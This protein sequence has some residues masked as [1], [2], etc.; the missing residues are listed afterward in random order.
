MTVVVG[1]STQWISRHAHTEQAPSPTQAASHNLRTSSQLLSPFVAST[2]AKRN[3]SS[4]D[5]DVE[6]GA[7]LMTQRRLSP[8]AKPYIAWLPAISSMTK[9]KRT[10]SRHNPNTVGVVPTICSRS[11][12]TIANNSNDSNGN[13][14]KQRTVVL[15][16]YVQTLRTITI[17]I[18]NGTLS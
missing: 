18:V 16:H 1:V 6:E 9:K 13:T 11:I 4:T 5:R 10:S 17:V 14:A 15:H 7:S 3:C 8:E 2:F 12:A